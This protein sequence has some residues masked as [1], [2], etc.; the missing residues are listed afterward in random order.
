MKFLGAGVSAGSASIATDGGVVSA[1]ET[2][3]SGHVQN[4]Y[5]KPTKDEL[6]DLTA[7]ETPAVGIT[8][9]GIFGYDASVGEWK[10]FTDEPI[11]NLREVDSTYGLVD[12]PLQSTEPRTIHVDAANGSDDATGMEDDPLATVQEAFNRT[13]VFIYHE[14]TI[15]VA[16]GEYLQDKDVFATRTGL[17]LVWAGDNFTLLGNTDSPENVVINAL[18]AK[19]FGKLEDIHFE[20]I[21]VKYLAQFAGPAFVRSC[22]FLGK[23]YRSGA[24]SGLSG[25]S[26]QV[27]LNKCQIGNPEEPPTYGIQPSLY[28]MYFVRKSSIYARDYAV[29]NSYGKQ[30]RVQISRNSSWEAGYGLTDTGPG[31]SA[32]DGSADIGSGTLFVYDRT[33]Y[34]GDGVTVCDDF[35]DNRL[36]DRITMNGGS[37]GGYRPEWSLVESTYASDGELI[38]PGSSGAQAAVP[39]SAGV[40][41]WDFDIVIGSEKPGR[42]PPDHARS[43]GKKNRHRDPSKGEF[44]AYFLSTNDGGDAYQLRFTADGT[45]TLDKHESGAMTTLGTGSW[46][47][48]GRHFVRIT[49]DKDG[50]MT[51]RVDGGEEIATVAEFQPRVS[52]E[53]AVRFN[54]GFDTE[55]RLDNLRIRQNAIDNSSVG[56][57]TPPEDGDEDDEEDNDEED[58]DEDEDEEGDEEDE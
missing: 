45:L 56:V 1:I 47:D 55:V 42:G 4:V 31:V 8:D 43:N 32:E 34:V 51:I 26:G 14:W 2:A 46:G 19:F 37:H 39:S 25:K 15:D 16:D 9:Q 24:T 6:P 38:F 48:S 13:P 10:Q 50:T 49:R 53:H 3:D 23:N 44:S 41:T 11:Q 27:F 7:E 28:D 30:A 21:T 18:N 40:G 33:M 29:D 12:R 58:D 57:L 5:T 22:R 20:G 17:H 35:D 54:N 36:R 52:D